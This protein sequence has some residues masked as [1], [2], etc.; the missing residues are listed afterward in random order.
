MD[1][2]EAYQVAYERIAAE[3]LTALKRQARTVARRCRILSELE[4]GPT[5]PGEGLSDGKLTVPSR[6][7]HR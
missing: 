2:A 7:G 4:D 3:K 6:G 5:W 1:L